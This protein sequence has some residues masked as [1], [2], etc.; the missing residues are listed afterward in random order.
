MTL[1]EFIEKFS[2]NNIIK[3]YYKTKEGHVTVLDD[4]KY[5]SM[6]WMINNCLGEYRHYKDNKV[7]GVVGILTFTEDAD[8]VNI[9]IE[10]LG[11]DQVYYEEVASQETKQKEEH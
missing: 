10:D 9:V 6:D 2:H 3:L 8:V 5:T 11:K 7:L 4:Y 1:G